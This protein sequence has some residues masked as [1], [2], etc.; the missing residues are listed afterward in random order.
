MWCC[1]LRRAGR[2]KDRRCVSIQLWFWES[3]ALFFVCVYFQVDGKVD[4]ILH[5]DKL[6]AVVC[7]AGGWAGGN[8]ASKRNSFHCLLCKPH[9]LNNLSHCR[10]CGK[11][12]LDVEAECLDVSACISTGLQAPVKVTP[13]SPPYAFQP[14]ID[15]W[16]LYVSIAALQWWGFGADRSKAS[17]GPNSRYIILPAC[18]LYHALSVCT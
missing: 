18:L 4:D 16:L 8:A 15:I 2:D 13:L 6:D 3:G 9:I 11:L 12:W 10:V 1:H 14:S 5:D 17:T 7:V